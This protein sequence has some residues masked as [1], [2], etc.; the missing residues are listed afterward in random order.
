MEDV[1]RIFDKIDEIKKVVDDGHIRLADKIDK[2]VGQVKDDIKSQA[3]DLEEI[4]IE[5]A[6]TS[7]HNLPDRMSKVEKAQQLADTERKGLATKISIIAGGSVLFATKG[8]DWLWG[9]VPKG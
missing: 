7:G 9:F 6:K 5:M 3:K 1:N 8:I 2:D 4:K